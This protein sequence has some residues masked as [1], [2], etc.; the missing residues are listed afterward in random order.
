MLS[1]HTIGL[2]VVQ[3]LALA[4]MTPLLLVISLLSAHAPWPLIVWSFAYALAIWI[5]ARLAALLSPRVQSPGAISLLLA[6]G[7]TFAACWGM[8][9]FIGLKELADFGAALVYAAP[10][11]AALTGYWLPMWLRKKARP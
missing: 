4:L 1:L 6:A 2:L 5:A 10:A 8:A 3:M 7:F 9:V 11:A